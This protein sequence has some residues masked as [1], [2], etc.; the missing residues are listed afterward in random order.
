MDHLHTREI[1]SA[2][3]E[4]VILTD[5]TNARQK[6]NSLWA[7][8]ALSAKNELTKSI[9][10]IR[11][12][13]IA[14]QNCILKQEQLDRMKLHQLHTNIT[15]FI[16]EDLLRTQFEKE[17]ELLLT[18]WHNNYTDPKQQSRIQQILCDHKS[19][20]QK[21]ETQEKLCSKIEE[22]LKSSKREAYEL[23]TQK[24]KAQGYV[25]A[26]L[27]DRMNAQDRNS[28]QLQSELNKE[29]AKLDLIQQAIIAKEEE[30]KSM[31]PHL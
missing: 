31:L 24:N 1:L 20:K 17:C 4:F 12:R 27:V 21:A 13:N 5:E 8:E 11:E 16:Q 2:Q 3:K 26:L 14:N 9:S 23:F 7:E 30:Y 18:G 22:G 29:Q 28:E 6:I 19:T 15:L 10:N 25:R